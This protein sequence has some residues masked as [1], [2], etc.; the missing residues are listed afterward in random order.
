MHFGKQLDAVKAKAPA[1]L[2][3]GYLE[4]TLLK[5]K[6]KC[7]AAA[8]AAEAARP[9]PPASALLGTPR[10][11][12]PW[13]SH[14]R[15]ASAHGA[16]LTSG[17]LL[18]EWVSLF[19]HELDKVNNFTDSR[20]EDIKLAIAGASRGVASAS[21]PSLPPLLR[22]LDAAA[23]S[24]VELERF[25]R[26]NGT[27]ILKIAKKY[28]RLLGQQTIPW[29]TARLRQQSFFTTRLDGFLV[30]LSDVYARVRAVAPRLLGE[31]AAAAT[32]PA[33]ARGGGGV[34]RP[35]ESFERSTAKYWV[36][37]E[38]VTRLKTAIIRHLPVLVFGRDT[39]EYRPVGPLDA[40]AI[41][42]GTDS[43]VITSIYFDTADLACYHARIR[44]EEGAQLLRVRWYGGEEAPPPHGE[45]FV[46]VKT[47][48][49]GGWGRRGEAF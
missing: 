22:E 24:V 3:Q 27:A 49:E 5:R 10:E 37:A 41:T 26:L 42:E 17:D 38:D 44:R 13:L 34:W 43:G 23:A 40:A 2:T 14:P 29:V 46:E 11:T 16:A 18:L 15:A 47:H 7:I 48:H 25:I 6:L 36:R 32:P 33:S 20:V 45:V 19:D 12:L 30:A 8:K 21:P 31:G 35:P 28:D 39:S 9:P 4:Y 1:A